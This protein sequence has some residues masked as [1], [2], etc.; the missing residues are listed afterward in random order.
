MAT[1]DFSRPKLITD[2]IS[3]L[4]AVDAHLDADALRFWSY[5]LIAAFFFLL[6]L[7]VNEKS[8]WHKLGVDLIGLAGIVL[9]GYL[10]YCRSGR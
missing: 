8:R 3:A 4:F 2:G 10:L 6:T 9:F 7:R 1:T 5:G